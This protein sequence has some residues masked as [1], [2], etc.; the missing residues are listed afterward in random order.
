MT[1]HHSTGLIRYRWASPPAPDASP[2]A[3]LRDPH[4]VTAGRAAF[5]AGAAV[6]TLGLAAN[7]APSFVGPALVASVGLS[8]AAIAQLAAEGLRHRALRARSPLE[9]RF[10]GSTGALV[11]RRPSTLRIEIW[12]GR[13]LAAVLVAAAGGDELVVFERRLSDEG[14]RH[15]GTAIGMAMAEL[16]AATRW[17]LPLRST[18]HSM[19]GRVK[20]RRLIPRAHDPAQI[21]S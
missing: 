18:E 10:A 15:L 4:L 1:Q 8:A 5:G 17:H 12:A 21:S 11:I 2:D 13:D 20:P 7:G 16:A 14:L 19:S 9:L 3:G 6:A